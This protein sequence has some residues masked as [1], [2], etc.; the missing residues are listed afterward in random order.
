MPYRQTAELLRVAHR[1]IVGDAVRRAHREG[2][3]ALRNSLIDALHLLMPLIGAARRLR[4]IIIDNRAAGRLAE[5]AHQ[6]V[7]HLGA[8]AAA[9]LNE[10]G[11]HLAQHVAEREDFL[12]IGPQCWDVDALRVVMAL[13]A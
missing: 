1:E 9:R 2:A 8:I 3:D 12:L 11:A 10:A 7:L 5:T 13:V 4:Q 6:P